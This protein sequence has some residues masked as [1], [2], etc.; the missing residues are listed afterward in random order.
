MLETKANQTCKDFIAI[1]VQ[2]FNS[3][4]KSILAS[5]CPKTLGAH[6]IR[7]ITWPIPHRRQLHLTAPSWSDSF[8]RAIQLASFDYPQAKVFW[9]NLFH[10]QYLK[11]LI[12]SGERTWL[13]LLIISRWNRCNLIGAQSFDEITEITVLLI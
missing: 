13:K 8:L 5:F 1:M 11:E 3:D 9:K 7:Q 12:V 10:F 4:L 6:L 2:C